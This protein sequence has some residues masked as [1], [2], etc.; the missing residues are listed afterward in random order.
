MKSLV[1]VFGSLILLIGLP[2][3]FQTIDDSVTQSYT[4][5]IS[6]VGTSA[7]EYAANVTLGRALYN[8]DSVAVSGISSNVS[9]D[10]PTA[11]S[12]NS[13]NKA[14]E[15]SGLADDETRTLTITFDIGSTTLPEGAAL[16]LT[17]L[18]RWF[19]IFAIIGS[20][21]GAVYAFFD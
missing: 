17:T 21:G 12:Y 9:S 10:T 4:Q 14:L 6:G 1:I 15:V 13:V 18:V 3:A 16:F 7:G 8:N 5:A 19:L 2:F 11:S 20:F